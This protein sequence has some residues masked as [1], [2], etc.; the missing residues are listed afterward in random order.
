M[1]TKN[2]ST[3]AAELVEAYSKNA[4]QVI[5]AYRA[6]SEKVADA[7][8]RRFEAAL[9]QSRPELSEETVANARNARKVCGRVYMKGVNATADTAEMLI[10]GTVKVAGYVTEQLVSGK[11]TSAFRKARSK[12]V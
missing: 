3:N 2:F 1:T 11:P 12:A 5:N 6:G 8:A 4:R 9:K 10:A 7:A